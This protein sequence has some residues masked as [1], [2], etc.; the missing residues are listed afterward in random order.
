M[1]T[2]GLVHTCDRPTHPRASL[3]VKRP[4]ALFITPSIHPRS[5]E[6]TLRCSLSGLLVNLTFK[7]GGEVKGA[8]EALPPAAA[9]EVA[10]G[11]SGAT[12]NGSGPSFPA[13][14]KPAKLGTFSG[15]WREC[16]R[17]A[18]PTLGLEGTVHHATGPSAVASAGQAAS[19]VSSA[20]SPPPPPPPPPLS[21]LDLCRL[22][23]MRLPRLW[24]ALHAAL[25]YNDPAHAQGGKVRLG[26]AMVRGDGRFVDSC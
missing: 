13:T 19:G 21:S 24:S 20:A 1:D 22:G 2:V 26:G 18:C 16:V 23:P 3:F 11:G 12:N 6:L 10:G 25:L 7:E 15:S 8:L 5:G 9:A 4:P 17:V 14:G